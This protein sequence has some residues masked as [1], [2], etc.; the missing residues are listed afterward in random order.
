MGNYGVDLAE[1]KKRKKED[2]CNGF[3][4][5]P[6][7]G[8]L[9]FGSTGVWLSEMLRTSFIFL[10]IQPIRASKTSP[11]MIPLNSLAL[12]QPQSRE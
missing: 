9:L 2:L 10:I 4:I 8:N 6:L 11:T 5:D 12:I 7:R 3:D 1:G